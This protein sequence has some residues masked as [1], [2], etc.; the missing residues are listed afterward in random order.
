MKLHGNAALSWQGRRRLAQR[1]VEEGCTLTAAAEAAAV[2]VRCA[3]KWS[4]RYPPREAPETRQRKRCRGDSVRARRLQP[5]LT[6]N[7][8]QSPHE[9]GL[10]SRNG[11]FKPWS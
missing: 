8:P 4:A 1:V 9:E 10:V 2:S 11:L 6:T 3:R 5:V 7:S